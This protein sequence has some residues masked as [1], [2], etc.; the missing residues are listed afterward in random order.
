MIWDV[1]PDIDIDRY[2]YCGSRR[3][4]AVLPVVHVEP[5]FRTFPS[6]HYNPTP[7]LI[8]LRQMTKLYAPFF[9][10]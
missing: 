2:S 8:T 9:R 6:V 5:L 3:I 10:I 1:M 4:R 7:C